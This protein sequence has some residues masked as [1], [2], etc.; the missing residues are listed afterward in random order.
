MTFYSTLIEICIYL[1][2]FSSYSELFVESGQFLPVPRSS[3]SNFAVTFGVSKLESH[4]AIVWNY[5]RHPTF[6][7]FDTILDVTDTHAD[8]QTHDD[9]IYRAYHSVAR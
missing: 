2:P 4:G 3:R 7:R 1:V 9:G 8:G 6:G 5:L